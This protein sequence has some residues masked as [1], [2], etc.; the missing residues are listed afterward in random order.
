MTNTCKGLTKNG[1]KCKR[2]IKNNTEEYCK[3][4][5]YQDQTCIVCLDGY[6][7]NEGPLP[8]GHWIHR[9]CIKKH[10]D[11]MQDLR[12]KEGYPPL[13]VGTCSVC[14]SPV[15]EVIPKPAPSVQPYS[16]IHIDADR[17]QAIYNEWC[18][19]NNGVTLAF[20][21]W[22]ELCNK[23]PNYHTPS[24]LVGAAQAFAD[25]VFDGSIELERSLDTSFR[26][27]LQQAW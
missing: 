3:L 13:K 15:P 6:A 24:I 7:R 1:T 8:C 12:A 22:I 23:F 17:M 14:R 9:E 5:E 19:L 26:Q 25:L 16:Y 20:L 11:S 18:Q 10:A 2:K 21:F 27:R 4:H